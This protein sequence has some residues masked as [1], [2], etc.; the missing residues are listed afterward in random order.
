MEQRSDAR[1][2]LVRRGGDNRYCR[3]GNAL[4]HVRMHDHRTRHGMFER[5]CIASIIE[6]ADFVWSRRLQRSNAPECSLDRRCSAPR[7]DRYGGKRMWAASGKEPRIAHWG[8]D[9][10][11]SDLLHQFMPKANSSFCAGQRGLQN[12]IL[13]SS[14]HWHSHGESANEAEQ[15]RYLA[16]AA[17]DVAVNSRWRRYSGAACSEAQVPCAIVRFVISV[18]MQTFRAIIARTWRPTG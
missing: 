15:A 8:F 16:A 18:P 10:H 9:R 12:D 7:R 5:H 1:P 4:Q 14:Y 13:F 3:I 11:H 6:K 17:A 2:A